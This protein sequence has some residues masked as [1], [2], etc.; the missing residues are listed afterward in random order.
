MMFYDTLIAL[1]LLSVPVTEGPIDIS[2]RA[3]GQELIDVS[4]Y[5]QVLDPREGTAFR[6]GSNLTYDVNLIRERLKNLADAPP[7]ED[8]DR[9]PPRHIVN[10]WMSFNYAYWRDLEMRMTMDAN[11]HY[12]LEV[13]RQ[14]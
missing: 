14:E 10:D 12:E 9:F 5:L 8:S 1:A 13:V 6:I 11:R 2:F 3:F 4:Q 7:V